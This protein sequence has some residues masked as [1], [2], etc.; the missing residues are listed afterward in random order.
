VKYFIRGTFGKAS[1]KEFIEFVEMSG[2]SLRWMEIDGDRLRF[3][4]FVGFLAIAT[5]LPL[6]LARG[7]GSPSQ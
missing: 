3:V 2:D 4:G 6:R 7:F 1:E 5:S